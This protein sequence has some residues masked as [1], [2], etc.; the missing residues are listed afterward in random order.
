MA[1]HRARRIR[2]RTVLVAAALPVALAA[3]PTSAAPAPGAAGVFEQQ[4]TFNTEYAQGEPSIAVNPT[5]PN[6]IILTF[7]ANVGYGFYGVESGHLPTQP[8]ARQQAMQGCDALVTFDAGRHWKRQQLPV[9]SWEI[10]PTRPNCSDTLVLFDRKG[11]AYVVGSSFQF[12]TFAV[13]QGDFRLISSKDGGRTW[14]KPSVVSPAVLSPGA[15]P[16]GWQGVRFYDDRE[17]MALDRSTGTIYVNGTQG[18]LTAGAQG[19]EEY[20][21]ASHDG[22]RTW[23]DALHVGTASSVQL[24]AA[25]GRMVFTNP[26]PL[27]AQR[28]CTCQDVVISTDGGRTLQRYS[29]LIPRSPTSVLGGASTVADPTRRGRFVIANV[30]GDSLVL[31][32]SI[33][34]GRRWGKVSTIT[35]PGRGAA[36]LWLDWSPEGVLGLGWRGTTSN[37]YGFWGAVSYDAGAHWTVHRISKG[38]SAPSSGL[39]VAGDDTSA[40]WVTKDRFYATWGDWRGGSLQ[41]W[42]GGFPLRKG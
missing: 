33:D 36:K 31:Y 29:T 40:V 30:E 23:G 18:R 19:N 32:R 35:V 26:P 38:D 27:G 17:F 42:W 10:D 2:L 6:N 9:S 37:G 8:R 34:G 24:A 16:T 3:V 28:E 41:T 11:T 20:V 13:G 25:F 12:P 15:D 39:W 7:L 14:S 4:L 21:A 5:N 22:G 1:Q